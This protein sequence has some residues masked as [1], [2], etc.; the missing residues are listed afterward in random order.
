MRVKLMKK[1]AA[2]LFLLLIAPVGLL[3]Q[4]QNVADW[5]AVES[6]KPG[7]K[8]I[9]ITKSG[10]E[11]AGSKRISNDELLFMEEWQPNQPKRTI[12]LTKAEIREVR[13]TTQRWIYKLLAYKVTATDEERE[14]G[15]DNCS[16]R[17]EK[18]IYLSQ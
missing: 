18:T 15:T 6:L 1:L 3:A 2:V 14:R 17:Q 7:T 11:F 9:V 13:K 8:I 10:R 5:K 12:S 4:Q 16:P